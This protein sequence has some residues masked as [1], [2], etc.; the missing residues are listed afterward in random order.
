MAAQERYDVAV[1]GKR[2]PGKEGDELRTTSERWAVG[3]PS[4]IG[5]AVEKM[6]QSESA[7]SEHGDVKSRML[8]V[9]SKH[10]LRYRPQKFT[11]TTAK[12]TL[13]GKIKD[14]KTK[15]MKKLKIIQTNDEADAKTNAM[16]ARFQAI[17]TGWKKVQVDLVAGFQSDK[18]SAGFAAAQHQMAAATKAVETAIKNGNKAAG[19]NGVSDAPA[20]PEDALPGLEQTTLAGNEESVKLVAAKVMGLKT[21]N[22]GYPGN[23]DKKVPRDQ[24]VMMLQKQMWAALAGYTTQSNKKIAHDTVKSKLLN[25]KMTR[26]KAARA[27]LAAL[28]KSLDAEFVNVPSV[29]TEIQRQTKIM[30]SI[31]DKLKKLET[32]G[33]QQSVDL[34]SQLAAMNKNQ[35][36]LKELCNKVRAT[37]DA[38]GS[39]AMM[40]KAQQ[41]Q[42]ARLL[43]AMDV[44]KGAMGPMN[45]TVQKPFENEMGALEA[46]AS[47]PKPKEEPE[48]EE[49]GS[50]E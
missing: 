43:A 39:A 49:E 6:C 15:L 32:D 19:A 45:P 8:S 41:A 28:K 1:R 12:S 47:K 26:V 25:A 24:I 18:D 4:K 38:F 46:A 42:L 27:K 14:A 31:D 37:K 10:Q 7:R 3:A 30:S 33:E 48:E 44:A 50:E 9:A 21:T 23:Y 16:L 36:D 29:K 13:A 20:N 17:E 34:N 22:T 2:F 5:L 40:V 35:Q 11:A